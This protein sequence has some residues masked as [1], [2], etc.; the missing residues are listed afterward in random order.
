MSD[1]PLI[2]PSSNYLPSLPA[3]VL[4]YLTYLFLSLGLWGYF[5]K[6][7][8]FKSGVGRFYS[9]RSLI[10]FFLKSKKINKNNLDSCFQLKQ[11]IQN[12]L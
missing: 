12:N 7:E 5:F 3:T 8:F 1:L 9:C 4:D 10:R 2:I 6:W 11:R